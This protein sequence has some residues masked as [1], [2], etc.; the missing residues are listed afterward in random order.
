V[1]RTDTDGCVVVSLQVHPGMTKHGFFHTAIVTRILIGDHEVCSNN[2]D[3]RDKNDY[4]SLPENL[5]F[6][7][8]SNSPFMLIGD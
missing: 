7:L 3:R 8:H 4:K 1:N 6:V 5:S 2:N